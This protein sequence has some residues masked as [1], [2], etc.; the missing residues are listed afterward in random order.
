MKTEQKDSVESGTTGMTKKGWFWTRYDKRR[1][2]RQRGESGETDK[3]EKG[4]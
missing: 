1:K 2:D 3:M 4:G